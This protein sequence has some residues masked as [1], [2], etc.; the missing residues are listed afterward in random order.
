MLSQG[1]FSGDNFTRAQRLTEHAEMLGPDVHIQTD[2]GDEPGGRTPWELFSEADA[3]RALATAE[4]A[5]Q[6]AQ[7]VVQAAQSQTQEPEQSSN[8]EPKKH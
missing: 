7:D 6:L 2:Y 8:D 4:R 5:F 3:R 1:V